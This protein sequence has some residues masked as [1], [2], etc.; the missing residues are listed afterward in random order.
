MPPT[1]VTTCQYDPLRDEGIEYA[2]RLAHAG[3]P[4]ELRHHPATFHG[5]GFIESASVTRR[6]FADEV[7]TLRRGLRI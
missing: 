2:R 5:S 6:M 7:E 3:V 1:F 4:T